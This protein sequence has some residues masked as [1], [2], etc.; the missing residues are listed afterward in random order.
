MT[1]LIQSIFSFKVITTGTI[2]IDTG[3]V[4]P[5]HLK[6]KRCFTLISVDGG[7]PDHY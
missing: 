3:S 5:D 6:L 7:E 1:K 4:A 2:S